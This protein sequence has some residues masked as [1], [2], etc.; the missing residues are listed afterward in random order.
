MF[1]ARV[2]CAARCG[3]LRA[4]AR[5]DRHGCLCSTSTLSRV[6][7]H[8]NKANKSCTAL[9]FLQSP[10]LVGDSLSLVQ[11]LP[12]FMTLFHTPS[13]SSYDRGT[14]TVAYNPLS[15]N[16]SI[17]ASQMSLVPDSIITSLC[18]C[19][20][21][22]RFG[23]PCCLRPCMLSQFFFWFQR[24][25]DVLLVPVPWTGSVSISLPPVC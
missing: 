23:S 9:D 2:N 24:A 16:C 18:T 20:C 6:C 11:R 7:L 14:T 3:L 15:W 8:L 1:D 12:P 21:G 13:S 17:T 22:C 5:S 25:I 10:R 19:S 4:V